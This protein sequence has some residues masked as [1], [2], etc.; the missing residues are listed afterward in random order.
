MRGRIHHK[1]GLFVRVYMDRK[2]TTD[3]QEELLFSVRFG[4]IGDLKAFVDK[5][6]ATALAD[7]RDESRNT[8]LH[9]TCAN[10][11]EGTSSRRSIFLI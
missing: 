4:E 10:G 2:P 9:M 7:V 8:I 11:H 5:Y 3:E 1:V 6:G